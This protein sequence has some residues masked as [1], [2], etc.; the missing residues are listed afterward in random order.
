MKVI[1]P[2]RPSA[3]SG[4]AIYEWNTMTTTLA[5]SETRSDMKLARKTTTLYNETSHE[6]S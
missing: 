3:L 6:D 4:K 2:A 5:S 1:A